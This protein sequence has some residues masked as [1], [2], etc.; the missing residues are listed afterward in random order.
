MPLDPRKIA[1]IQAVI[2]R[3]WSGRQRSVVFVYNSAGAYSYSA[4]T[5]IWRPQN[6]IDPQI[7]WLSGAAP[8]VPADITMIAALSISFTGVVYVADTVT[9]TSSAVAAAPKYEI[10]EAVPSG[11]IPGGTHI[12]V[13][14][15][16]MR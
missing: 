4:Q 16:R 2:P 8:G 9:A 15:R 10:I 7:P 6:V 5:V 13:A 3:T 14:L 12:R 1:H 11:I